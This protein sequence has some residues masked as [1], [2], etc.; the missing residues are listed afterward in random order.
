MWT[1]A[2][3]AVL[4]N[5]FQVVN[6]LLDRGFV[7]HLEP[8]ALIAQSAAMNIIFLMISLAMTLA[9]SATALVSRAFGAENPIEY[10]AACSQSLRVSLIAGVGLG[11]LGAL[12]A[13]HVASLLLPASEPRAIAAMTSYIIAFAAGMPAFF[14]IQSIAGSLRGIGDTKSPMIISGIQIVLHISLNF[15]LIFPPKHLGGGIVLPG[16]D[17]GLLGAGI[18]LSASAWISALIYLVH[19]SRTP[20]GEL[21]L[22]LL[23]SWAWTK[24]IL[25]IAMPAAVMA[26]L[27]VLSLT[28]LTLIIK[29]V[30]DGAN[31]IAGLGVSFSLEGIMF[32]P[33]FGFSVAAAALVGQS[34]GMGRPDRAERLGWTA[35]HISAGI[36]LAIVVPIFVFAEP[37]A[38]LMTDNKVEIAAQAALLLRYL[39]V[40]E[41]M[42]AYAMVTIGALQGAGDT[43]RPMWITVIS[44]WLLRVP[45]AYV[46]AIPMAMGATGVWLSFAIS[47]AVQGGLAIGAFKQGAWKLK[48]V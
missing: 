44:Q 5:S 25:R 34:L 38:L 13:P 3:P 14:I 47:Q 33:A 20:L 29:V 36:V 12:T 6:S 40:T 42:F 37:V 43:V 32:M 9:T 4:L 31:A 23:P 24:R 45:L 11:A 15:I 19:V 18:A 7:G 10:R 2:W 48:E 21:G 16:F 39:C 22:A 17:M 30:P 35:S 1:L 46:L 41:V 26:T 27:R 28:A 8:A